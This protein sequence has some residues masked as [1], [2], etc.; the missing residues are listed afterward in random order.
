M[1]AIV[2]DA[3]AVRRTGGVAW[4]APAGSAPRTSTPAV[5]RSG[6]GGCRMG[7]S[8]T[9]AAGAG[10]STRSWDGN[11]RNIAAIRARPNRTR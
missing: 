11:V 1:P 9:S 10:R 8:Y 4:Y 2:A 5:G 6:P 3:R 7:L